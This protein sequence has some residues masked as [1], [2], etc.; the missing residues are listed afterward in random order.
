MNDSDVAMVNGYGKRFYPPVITKVAEE[1]RKVAASITRKAK[2]VGFEYQMRHF[3][4]N[5]NKRYV[6]EESLR[7]VVSAEGFTISIQNTNTEE[8]RLFI[9]AFDEERK[10]EGKQLSSVMSVV[11]YLQDSLHSEAHRWDNAKLHN[12]QAAIDVMLEVI[13]FLT[14]I[15]NKVKVYDF[16]MKDTEGGRVLTM[17]LVCPGT[18]S[19]YTRI[20]WNIV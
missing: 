14:N 19:Y 11:A 2:G 1:M 10:N 6:I 13:N 4:C 18:L 7:D 5:H 20:D 12:G 17:A 9:K 15:K 3:T 8:R 16:S